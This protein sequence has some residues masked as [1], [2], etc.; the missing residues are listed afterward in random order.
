[1]ERIL[2]SRSRVWSLRLR[3]TRAAEPNHMSTDQRTESMSDRRAR[4]SIR[5]FV[6]KRNKILMG[7][8]HEALRRFM[9]ERKM[10]YPRNKALLEIT[11][12]KSITASTGLPRAYRLL[13]KDWLEVRGYHSLD[14]GDL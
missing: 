9:K 11:W 8:D 7:N 5:D 10:P 6:Q 13:S 12:H 1:M 4:E 2:K 14:D 3:Y